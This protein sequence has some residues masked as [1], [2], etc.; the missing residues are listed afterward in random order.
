MKGYYVTILIVCGLGC[1]CRSDTMRPEVHTIEVPDARRTA[2]V[3]PLPSLKADQ[4]MTIPEEALVL[5]IP[6]AAPEQVEVCNGHDDDGDGYIDEGNQPAPHIWGTGFLCV[7]TST[8]AC[9]C[10]EYELWCRE[11]ER[12]GSRDWVLTDYGRDPLWEQCY[13][14]RPWYELCEYL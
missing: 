5:M 2:F 11:V 14:G 8:C 6:Q 7:R 4:V 1:G 12:N 13:Q 10:R 9:E 3:F